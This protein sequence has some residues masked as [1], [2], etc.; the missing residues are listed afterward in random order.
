MEVRLAVLGYLLEESNQNADRVKKLGELLAILAAFF[1]QKFTFKFQKLVKEVMGAQ[2]EG[3]GKSGSWALTLPHSLWPISLARQPVVHPDLLPHLAEFQSAYQSKFPKR[4]LQAILPDV[5]SVELLFNRKMTLRVSTLQAS[6]LL[7]FTKRKTKWTCTDLA[8][9]VGVQEEHLLE[10]LRP[11]IEEKILRSDEGSL[12]VETSTSAV[13]NTAMLLTSPQILQM[14]EAAHG[15]VA[16][17][18]T[19]VAAPVQQPTSQITY[20]HKEHKFRVQAFIVRTLKKE[21]SAGIDELNERIRAHFSLENE[22][23][24]ELKIDLKQADIDKNVTDLA[25]KDFLAVDEDLNLYEYVK[26]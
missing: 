6:A 21:Q 13:K 18:D 12:Q 19:S 24:S 1:G 16:F 26:A 3:G 9:R 10:A 17:K 2:I 8:A 25:Q 15:M 5:G 4:K 20:V 22:N 14:V 11:A 23:Q 7:L